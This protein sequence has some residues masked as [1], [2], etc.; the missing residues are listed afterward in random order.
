MEK[1]IGR[2]AFVGFMWLYSI[3]YFIECLGFDDTTE[4]MTVVTVFWLFTLFVIL[5]VISLMK[6]VVANKE[7]P[8][9]LNIRILSKIFTDYRFHLVCSLAIYL[10]LIPYLGFYLS[11]FIA[12]CAFSYILG[13]R[14]GL[15]M[16]AA[17]VIVLA[18]IYVIFTVLLNIVLPQGFFF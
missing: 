15:K 6:T 3:Y 7:K 18:F 16:V 13:T 2:L 12:F 10:L 14:G 4:K 9:A 5:E 17:G 11:S 8:P 1:A